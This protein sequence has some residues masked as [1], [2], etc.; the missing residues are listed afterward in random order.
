MHDDAGPDFLQS[1]ANIGSGARKRG[2]PVDFRTGATIFGMRHSP[3]PWGI[4]MRRAALY[5]RVSTLN[6]Q[7]TENQERALREVADRMG[8]EIVHVYRDQGISG[9]KGRNGRPAF[10][11]LCKGA[12][13]REFDIVMAWSVDRLGRSLQDLVAF[14]TELHALKIDLYLHQQGVDTTTP[15][16]KS[17]SGRRIAQRNADAVRTS[18]GIGLRRDLAN[19]ALNVNTGKE[20]QA[21]AERQTDP[22]RHREI[23]SDIDHRLSDVGPR[24]GDHTLARRDHLPVDDHPHAVADWKKPGGEA[25]GELGL[26]LVRIL[27]HLSFGEVDM[28]ELQRRQSAVPDAGQEREGDQNAVPPLDLGSIGHRGEHAVD[29]LQG[30]GRSFAHGLCNSRILLGEPKIFRIRIA[31]PGAVPRLPRKPKHEGAKG[32][33]RLQEGGLAEGLSRR[34]VRC[35]GQLPPEG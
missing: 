26:H 34:G 18:D 2:K 23:C 12:A 31:N 10:D 7:T 5:V 17:E 35:L 3:R 16:G 30:G 24:D 11:T 33:E 28:L 21:D 13:R 29:L 8:C 27:R 32:V 20:L 9:A 15:G 14:L 22:Q 6:G 19:S 1:I 4:T 25:L